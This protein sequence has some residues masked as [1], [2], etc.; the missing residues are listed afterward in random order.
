MATKPASTPA[1]VQMLPD[2]KKKSEQKQKTHNRSGFN[3]YTD[4]YLNS[5][6]LK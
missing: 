6:A 4:Q 5:F 2:L 1:I 3:S